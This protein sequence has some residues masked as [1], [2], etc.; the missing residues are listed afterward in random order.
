MARQDF[1]QC[2]MREEVKAHGIQRLS[3]GQQVTDSGAGQ[4]VMF[5][6]IGERSEAQTTLSEGRFSLH[7]GDLLWWTV[8]QPQTGRDDIMP[9]NHEAPATILVL[10]AAHGLIVVDGNAE[11]PLCIP[12]APY[13]KESGRADHG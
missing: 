7:S 8:A 6:G 12:T 11:W 10:V 1:L 4:A 9:P 2:V 13:R 5:D 3:L